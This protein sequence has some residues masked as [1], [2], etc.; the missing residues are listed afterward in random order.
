MQAVHSI[1]H[2]DAAFQPPKELFVSNPLCTHPIPC[3]LYNL[4]AQNLCNTGP[5]TPGAKQ[6][7]INMTGK[8]E[9]LQELASMLIT[10]L[11]VK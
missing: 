8:G 10:M 6:V 11:N 1:L 4:T 9:L 7:R 3:E 5:L 2:D